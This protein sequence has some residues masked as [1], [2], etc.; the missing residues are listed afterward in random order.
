MD[1]VFEQLQFFRGF[2]LS[3]LQKLEKEHADIIIGRYKHKKLVDPL[4]N[5]FYSIL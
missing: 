5:F 2:T 4:A 3:N 1:K